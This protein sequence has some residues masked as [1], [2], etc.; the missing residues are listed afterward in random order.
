MVH[1]LSPQGHYYV[2]AL[3]QALQGPKAERFQL[4]RT[5]LEDY[6]NHVPITNCAQR[7]GLPP[8]TVPE[9]DEAPPWLIVY[10]W[11][12]QSIKQNIEHKNRETLH[13][14]QRDGLNLDAWQ[15][16]ASYPLADEAK[17]ESEARKLE[18]LLSSVESQGYRPE[19]YKDGGIGATLMVNESGE[20]VWYVS[21][22]FHRVCVLTALGHSS[23]PASVSR[24]VKRDHVN[25]WPLVRTGLFSKKAALDLFDQ[26]FEGKGFTAHNDWMMKG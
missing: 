6:K 1:K 26:I 20:R 5:T 13:E 2:K 14:N 22:G 12:K 25:R 19:H 9:L 4:I 11:V 21:G 8:G 18:C 16:G 7:L 17:L 10:P 23:I 3:S 24:I 15:G